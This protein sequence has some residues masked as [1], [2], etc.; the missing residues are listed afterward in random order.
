MSLTVSGH[1]PSQSLTLD[2]VILMVNL[3]G[4]DA[5]RPV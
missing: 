1:F 2:D 5:S 4:E 3:I